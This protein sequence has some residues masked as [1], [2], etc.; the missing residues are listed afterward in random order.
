MALPTCVTMVFVWFVL[1]ADSI[2][3]VKLASVVCMSFCLYFLPQLVYFD[4][5]F[6]CFIP[7]FMCSAT[8]LFVCFHF[9]AF[10]GG[11]SK[12]INVY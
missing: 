5:F 8:S 7:I 4:F 10:F 6:V 1:L 9:F 3:F 11:G 2:A 12:T